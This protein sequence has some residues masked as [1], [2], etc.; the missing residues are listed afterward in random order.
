[1]GFDDKERRGQRIS[2]RHL[3]VK[4]EEDVKKKAL[5]LSLAVLCFGIATAVR[6]FCCRADPDVMCVHVPQMVDET[7]VRIITN[8]ALDEILGRYDDVKRQIE[9]DMT[10]KLVLYHESDRLL[11]EAYRRHIEARLREVGLD[12][13]ILAA[14]HNPPPPVATTN[15]PVQL[16]AGRV[17]AVI[18]V[19]EMNSVTD[20]NRAV[21]A[22]SYARLGGDHPGI[23][24]GRNERK[25]TV[26]YNGRQ[27]ASRNIE[28]AIVSAGFDANDIEA[29]PD[30]LPDGWRPIR[31]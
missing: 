12:A 27:L 26:S 13:H 14:R 4:K 22:I 15:G 10:R 28:H 5:V 19:P 30:S 11:H 17:T 2:G 29:G 7:G 18:S 25:L 8:A 24:V 9:I 6:I 16:W 1:M 31:L 21:D 20:A 23:S 3:S